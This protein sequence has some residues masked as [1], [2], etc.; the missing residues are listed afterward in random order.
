ME[1]LF[2]GPSCQVTPPQLEIIPLSLLQRDTAWLWWAQAE[3]DQSSAPP[4]SPSFSKMGLFCPNGGAALPSTALSCSR[5]TLSYQDC[6]A[7]PQC[8]AQCLLS[9]NIGNFVRKPLLSQNI[10]NFVRKPLKEP[11]MLKSKALGK[12]G[13]GR[14]KAFPLCCLALKRLLHSEPAQATRDLVCSQ[15][16]R[17]PSLGFS[18]PPV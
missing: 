6:V 13:W 10:G 16:K 14:C 9:Q 17:N 7:R 4:L 1:K 18:F 5:N 15:K 8:P 12:A 2:L 3:L 11:N